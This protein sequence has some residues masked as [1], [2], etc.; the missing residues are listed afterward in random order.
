MVREKKW[1]VG[2]KKR[3]V[4]GKGWEEE[5]KAEVGWREKG[6][7]GRWVVGLRQRNK[8]Q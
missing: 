1:V 6:I 4:E 5:E 3:V 2:G 8:N 7:Y